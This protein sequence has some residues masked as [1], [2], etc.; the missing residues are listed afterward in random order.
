[1]NVEAGMTLPP[2]SIN[3]LRSVTLDPEN[4]EI[5][6]MAKLR[7]A[8]MVVIR[9]GPIYCPAS[10]VEGIDRR[11]NSVP[12]THS[13]YLQRLACQILRADEVDGLECPSYA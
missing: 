10:T 9:Y 7:T 5:K 8:Q 2:L 12:Q 13:R 11:P 1:M 6:P 4:K 3:V